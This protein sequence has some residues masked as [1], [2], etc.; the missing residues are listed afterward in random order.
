MN[1]HRMTSERLRIRSDE[2]LAQ[3]NKGLVELSKILER[4]AVPHYLAS[5]TLLGAVREKNFIPWDWDVQFYFRL[6]DVDGRFDELLGLMQ[7]AGFRPTKTD[8]SAKRWKILVTKYDTIYEMTAWAAAGRLRVRSDWKLPARFFD[9]PDQ[10]DFLG[11]RYICMTPAEDFLVHCYGDDW[12]VPKRID[13]KEK[14]LA[15]SFYQ[16]S[17]FRRSIEK[18]M[19][20]NGSAVKKRL[21]ALMPSRQAGVRERGHET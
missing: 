21:L 11:R 19:E 18:W 10:I 9:D 5:G 6:E 7:E 14:Y 1:A 8:D 13:D 16:K 20:T 4:V 17:A 15:A 12:R 2:E 3:Q